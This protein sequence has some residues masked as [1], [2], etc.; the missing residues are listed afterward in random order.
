MMGLITWSLNSHGR[1]WMYLF[2]IDVKPFK[3]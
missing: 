3:A 2:F 1:D